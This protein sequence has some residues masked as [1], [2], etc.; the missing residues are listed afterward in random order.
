MVVILDKLLELIEVDIIN[1][2]IGDVFIIVDL[3]EYKDYE[4]LIDLEE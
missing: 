3:F 4:I 1:L 2:E